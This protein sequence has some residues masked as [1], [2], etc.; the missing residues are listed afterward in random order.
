MSTA[1]NKAFRDNGFPKGTKVMAGLDSE[2]ELILNRGTKTRVVSVTQI[3]RDST[4]HRYNVEVEL[5]VV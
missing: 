5:E 3:P 1:E 2:E 4:D